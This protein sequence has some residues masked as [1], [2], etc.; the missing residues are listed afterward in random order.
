M[1]PLRHLSGEELRACLYCIYDAYVERRTLSDNVLAANASQ[2]DDWTYLPEAVEDYNMYDTQ[3]VV[4]GFQR[5]A[6]G[7][8]VRK[9]G[10]RKFQDIAAPVVRR[11]DVARG[12]KWY[13]L[14]HGGAYT[15]VHHDASGLCTWMEIPHGAKCWIIFKMDPKLSRA[16]LEKEFKKLVMNAGKAGFANANAEGRSVVLTPGSLLYVAV[17]YRI[18]S[19][20][21]LIV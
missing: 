14:A 21:G 1:P 11:N 10:K 4:V 7:K 18:R 6:E 9:R 13:L 12:Y 17:W 3:D 16:E 20:F 19:M 2:D 15:P 8:S 5:L